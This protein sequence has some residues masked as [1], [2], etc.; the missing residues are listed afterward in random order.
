MPTIKEGLSVPIGASF[1][2]L[3]APLLPDQMVPLS[4]IKEQ[5]DRIEDKLD[6]LIQLLAD[7]ESSEREMVRPGD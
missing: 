5:L 4:S 1:E 6:R 2:K 7:A 3:L